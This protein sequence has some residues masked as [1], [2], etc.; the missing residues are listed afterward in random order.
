MKI[1]F[2][3]ILFIN[4]FVGAA[5]GGAVTDEIKK[6]SVLKGIKNAQWG[7]SVKYVDT[8]KELVSLN[9]NKNLIP[10]SILKVFIT[11]AALEYF[12]PDYRFETKLYYRGKI[13]KGTLFGNIYIVGGGDPSLG[14]SRVMGALSFNKV[15]ARL[16]NSLKRA[17]IK[18]IKGGI[19]ADDSLFNGISIPSSWAWEDIGNYYAAWP[20][21]LSINDNIY[22]LYF[23]P[24]GK[25]GGRAK[26]IKT[27][28]NIPGLKFTNFMKTG[29][30]GSGDHGYIFNMP[31]NYRAVL[32]GTIPLGPKKFAIKGAIPDPPVFFAEHFKKYLKARGIKVKGKALRVLKKKDYLPNKL[33]IEIKSPPLKNIIFTTNKKS[34]NLYAEIL[35]RHLA[36]INGRA[37]N[38]EAGLFTLKKFLSTNGVDVSEMKLKDASGLSRLNTVK[39]ENFTN[40]LVEAY[41]KKYFDDFYNSLVAPGENGATGHIKRFALGTFLENNI[42]IKSGSLNGVR[43]YTGYFET[44]KNRLVAFTS[45]INNYSIKA[46]EIDGIQKNL[47]LKIAEEY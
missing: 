24:S 28:P 1:I 26:V 3:I 40:F 9:Q 36:V 14:S 21:A 47:L 45:I 12:G 20:S 23:K 42:M 31:K 44:K 25:V 33:L 35:L 34:F 10:A 22:K 32:R 30:K 41:N 8:G 13:K 16:T 27:V 46:S 39:A 5:F 4:F 2:S 29:P 37:G 43:A 18:R 7:L 15:F 19:Y 6:I 38:L 11:A 17:G